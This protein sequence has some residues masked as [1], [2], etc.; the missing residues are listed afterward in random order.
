MQHRLDALAALVQRGLH[1][2]T[3]PERLGTVAVLA[4][5][6]VLWA[7][8]ERRPRGTWPLLGRDFLT[9][10]AYWL[11]YSAGI[12]TLLGFARLFTAT[13]W[14]IHRWLPAIELNLVRGKAGWI[15]FASM[16]VACDFASYWWHRA[17][18]ASRILWL[19]HRPHHSQVQLTPFTNYRVHIADMIGRGVLLMIPG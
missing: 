19:V 1:G 3:T 10:V 2:W 17:T 18:H 5:G 13:Q 8:A 11:F 12:F 15:Q 6:T 16:V 14:A 4:I 7:F 9:D